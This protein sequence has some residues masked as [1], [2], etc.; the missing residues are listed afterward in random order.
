MRYI[1]I[2]NVRRLKDNSYLHEDKY[3]VATDLAHV[4]FTFFQVFCPFGLLQ[5]TKNS[6]TQY[7]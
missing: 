5:F 4:Q 6:I 3:E 1:S 2:V 7:I